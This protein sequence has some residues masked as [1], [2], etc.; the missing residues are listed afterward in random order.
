MTSPAHAL[1]DHLAEYLGDR[2]GPLGLRVV[3]GPE[4]EPWIELCDPLGA[5]TIH[6]EARDGSEASRVVAALSGDLEAIAEGRATRIGRLL[7]KYLS[8]GSPNLDARCI[9]I[10]HDLP[11]ADRERLAAVIEDRL[12][13]LEKT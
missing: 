13:V 5:Y 10:V 9:S 11:A 4:E 7:A 2:K 6:L 12:S 8:L 1:I 3:D